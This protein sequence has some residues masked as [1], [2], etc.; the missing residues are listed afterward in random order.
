MSEVLQLWQG[1]FGETPPLA[2][3]L[4]TSFPDRWVRFHTLPD[5][6]RYA[7]TAR[8]TCEIL[9]RLDAVSQNIYEKSELCW[10]I[11]AQENFSEDKKVDKK[12]L[13]ID[14]FSLKYFH[15]F[16]HK[17]S[18]GDI[19]HWDFYATC[20]EWAAQE[21]HSLFG[22]ISN[23]QVSQMLWVSIS[24]HNVFAPYDGGVDVILKSR[25]ERDQLRERFRNWL[26]AE[27]SGL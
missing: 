16:S 5:S 1:Q 6:K 25:V 18:F 23:D 2:H 19:V 8:E 3:L 12:V 10:L 22:A 4:R 15:S 14:I 9:N 13:E 11:F 20:V 27:P 7:S 17:D 21:F 26:S 24:S